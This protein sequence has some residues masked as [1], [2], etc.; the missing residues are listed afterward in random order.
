MLRNV[1]ISLGLMLFLTSCAE[2]RYLTRTEIV[3]ERVPAEYLEA[4]VIP[5]PEVNVI[6]YCPEYVEVLKSTVGECNADK[7]DARAWNEREGTK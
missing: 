6:G 7:A 1:L 4:T 5:G 2:T 3:R